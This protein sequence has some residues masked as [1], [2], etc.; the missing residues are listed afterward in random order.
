VP[1][2]YQDDRRID[3]GV[4]RLDP[5]ELPEFVAVPV[6]DGLPD[7]LQWVADQVDLS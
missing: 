3:P 4:A 1:H 7:Y 5:Y 2:D 6:C